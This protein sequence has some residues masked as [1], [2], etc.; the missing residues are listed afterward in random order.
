MEKGVPVEITDGVEISLTTHVEDEEH[1]LAALLHLVI[2][3]CIA[4]NVSSAI[5]M[6]TAMLKT[7]SQWEDQEGELITVI[8]DAYQE[9]PLP[10]L[11]TLEHWVKDYLSSKAYRVRQPTADFLQKQIFGPP[12][13]LEK[14]NIESLRSRHARWLIKYLGP[15]IQAAYRQER[16]RTKYE[17]MIRVLSE[18]DLYLQDLLRV[19]G[20]KL[21]SQDKAGPP[22]VLEIEYYEA[23]TALSSLA[24]LNSNIADWEPPQ[25]ASLDIS[26]SV[27]PGSDLDGDDEDED[28]EEEWSSDDSRDLG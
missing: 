2:H 10:I 27:E 13:E 16:P 23:K 11:S 20:A 12:F 28:E 8:V 19:V 5:Q 14:P 3:Y 22:A 4:A 25:I 6:M 9:A 1:S 24:Q 15:L 7:M 26:R 17:D 21:F 18:A